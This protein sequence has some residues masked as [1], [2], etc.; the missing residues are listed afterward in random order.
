MPF[1]PEAILRVL[2]KHGVVCVVVGGVAAVLHGSPMT[3]QDLDL[4][5]QAEAANLAR[6]SNALREL[7]ARIRTRDAPDGLPFNHDG[8]SLG[9][10][11]IW[12]LITRFG[13]LDVLFHPAG[14]DGFVQL[15][16]HAEAMDMEGVPV[17][18]AGLDDVIRSKEL[19]GRAKDL[20]THPYL[21]RLRETI[22][23]SEPRGDRP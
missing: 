23:E 18:V 13:D 16:P 15:A 5:P 12:N 22:A 11:E 21:R 6:L 8:A 10:G 1:D 20:A 7:G 14:F 2:D 3:T 19:A 9:R 17:L 4:V